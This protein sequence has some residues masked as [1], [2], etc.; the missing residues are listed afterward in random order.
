MK[1]DV[2]E[3]LRIEH[4]EFREQL[5]KAVDAGGSTGEA[6]RGVLKVLHPHI[7]LE[8]EFA[9]PPLALLPRLAA[10]EIDPEMSKILAKT[11][12]LKSELPR[13]LDEHKLIVAAL[14]KLMQAATEEKLFGFAKFAQK[15][16]LHA[17]MEEEILY[18]AS[19][20]VG[21]YVREKLKK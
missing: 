15:L 13:M 20:L 14:R 17:Q 21:E 9:V 10:G 18:P 7:L 5:Q 8:Q 2:P 19:I 11:D 16:I 12:V 6:A 3:A 4:E 1:S